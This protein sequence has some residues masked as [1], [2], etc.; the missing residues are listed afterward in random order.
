VSFISGWPFE[1]ELLRDKIGAAF[2]TAGGI[3]AGEEV[4]Q[5]NIL[6]SMMVF[7]MIIVGGPDWK[8][9]FGA[10]AVVEEFPFD[11]IAG[12]AQVGNQFLLKGESLG[13]RVA[14]LSLKL[15]KFR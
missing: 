7:G 6:H 8:S 1:G 12:G 15:K 13:R 5:L 11:S 10:S 9:A 2:V 14:E 4:A 3:S